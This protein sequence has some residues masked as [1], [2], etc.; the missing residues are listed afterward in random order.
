MNM[1]DEELPEMLFGNRRNHTLPSRGWVCPGDLRI[2]AYA[3]GVL[4]KRK[5]EL[6][7][8]HLASCPRCRLIVADVVR[9]QRQLDTPQPPLEL[10]RRAVGTVRQ[11]SQSWRW[12]WVSVGALASIALVATLAVLSREP[13][14][15]I[16]ISP[17]A[18]S[19]PYV[20]KSE[21][22]EAPK[23]SERDLVRKPQTTDTVPTILFPPPDS[24]VRGDLLKFRWRPISGSRYYGVRVVKSDGDVVWEDQ[25]EKSTS[26]PPSDIA[27]T[28][29][30]YFVWVTA[31]LADGRIAKSPPVRFLVKR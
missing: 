10:M 9:A 2:A 6:L 30:S 3:D 7:E 16:V 15:I 4:G 20:A 1:T 28:E 18:P 12:I 29:G 14:Q 11:D 8:L 23:A 19:A 26:H 25:T 5:T 31:N 27:L 22:V 17:P 24:V 13:K 21:P